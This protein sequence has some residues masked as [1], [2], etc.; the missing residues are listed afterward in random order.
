MEKNIFNTDLNSLVGESPID[1]EGVE[2]G[3]G[4]IPQSPIPTK[5][6]QKK[7]DKKLEDEEEASLIDLEENKEE[8]EEEKED[9][10]IEKETPSSGKEKPSSSPL[11]PYAKLLIDEG[12]L[13]NLDLKTFDGT[14]DGLKQAMVNEIIGAVEYYKESLPERVKNLINNYEDGVPLEKLLEID[15][16]EIEIGSLSEDKVK[17]DPNLQKEVIKNYLKK[18]TKFSEK[19]IENMIQYYEDSGE[20]ET[21]AL[22]ATKDLNEIVVKDKEKVA[23]EAKEA[24]ANAQRQ[25]QQELAELNKKVQGLDE[26]VPGMKLNTKIKGEV[27]KS[28]TTPAGK[29]RNGNPVNRIVAA[30]MEN[31]M[32]FEIK[33][34]YL[35]EITK[36]FTDFSKLVEKGKKDSM[37]EFEESIEKQDRS[38][39]GTSLPDTKINKKFIDSITKTF[40]IS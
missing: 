3:T 28:M 2:D 17:E 25:A 16:E 18:T 26:I 20:L 36:G 31:P 8:D 9:E 19:K 27:L 6:E 1:V 15:K 34:H 39:D 7:E 29:D 12:V 22:T 33:L 37:R 35:F 21:E 32:E 11:T 23:K 4:F 40:N 5:E 30:R 38:T 24:A 13:P 10:E 14:A